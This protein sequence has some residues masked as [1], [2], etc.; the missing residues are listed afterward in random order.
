VIPQNGLRFALDI[1]LFALVHV[2]GGRVDR[3]G[4]FAM[5][6]EAFLE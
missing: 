6:E 2:F 4:D 5:A 1:A 3:V